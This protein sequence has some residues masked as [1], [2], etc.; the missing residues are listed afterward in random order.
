MKKLFSVL[1][2]LMFALSFNFN[3]YANFEISTSPMSQ[4]FIDYLNTPSLYSNDSSSG[5]IP[6]P[7]EL[8]YVE[9]NQTYDL[10]S[11]YNISS[12]YNIQNPKNFISPIK[13]QGQDGVC[14]A[15]STIGV[16]ESSLLKQENLTQLDTYDFSENHMRHALSK[17][18]NNLLGFER[19]H[20]G[21]GNFKMG[22]AYLTRGEI[23]GPVWEEDDIYEYEQPVRDVADTIAIGAED[24]YV[25]KSITL[26][27][28]PKKPTQAQ[29][30][31]RINEIKQLVMDYGSVTLSYY[32]DN[33][34]YDNPSEPTNYYYN[35]D[36]E[37][38]NSNHAVAIVGWDDTYSKNNF[39]YKPEND[40]AFLIKNSWGERGKL[41]G[42][43]YMSYDDKLAFSDINTIASVESR[44]FY[45]NLYEYDPFGNSGGSVGFPYDTNAYANVFELISENEILTSI[46]TNT[47]VP[48]SY[49]KFFVSTDGNFQNLEEVSIQD[50]GD[51]TD[52]GYQ[53]PDTGYT[54]FKLESPI[55]L[56][57]NKFAIAI[58]VYNP[59]YNNNGEAHTIPM[60]R[61]TS[62]Y[63][64]N[65]IQHAGESFIAQ[66]ISYLMFNQNIYDLAS[67]YQA[68]ACI[69]A[70]TK[71][72]EFEQ[73]Y[74]I[75]IAS[76]IEGGVVEAN[77][78]EAAEGTDIKLDV[79]PDDGMRLK[80]N[81]L[82]Y[83]DGNDEYI[84]R[85]N[86]FKM[87]ASDVIVY[88]E[89]EKIPYN[90]FI[91]HN[92]DGGTVKSSHLT[93]AEGTDIIVIVTPDKGMQ[94]V[95]DSLKYDDGI[96]E[97]IINNNTF[98]MP[99]SDVT[100][101]AEFE[102]A[103]YNITIDNN[104]KGGTIKSDISNAKAGTDVHL[105]ILPDE[106]MRLKENSLKYNDGTKDYIISNNTFK[107]PASSVTVYAEFEK[108]PYN[109]NIDESIAGGSVEVNY[110]TVTEG[111][112]IVVIVKAD[113]GMQ[114]KENSL[115][116][117]DGTDE[118]IIYGNTFKMPASDI[119]I[120]AEFEK[121]P[122]K[123]III[124]ITTATKDAQIYYTLDGTTPT[125]QSTK[126]TDTIKKSLDDFSQSTLTIKAIAFKEGFN[127]SDIAVKT[128]P[129]ISKSL[130]TVDKSEEL[131]ILKQAIQDANTVLKNYNDGNV[132]LNEIINALNSVSS[133]IVNYSKV[134]KV[135]TPVIKIEF[136]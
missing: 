104:I 110:L 126:Y 26:A 128:V 55:E 19:K 133:A 8:P 23:N 119:T 7:Y 16:M 89:F 37:A 76:D 96:H 78:S 44:E 36:D 114:L 121:I 99:A 87:P 38:P 123:N 80:E 107:M 77:L 11:T 45:D 125:K 84:I 5:Y 122:S 135:S 64:S 41:A 27:D 127:D 39:K 60:E 6:E 106:G 62:G 81:S 46:S 33:N 2:S 47:I 112:D 79:I 130:Y 24:F 65:A 4:K 111:T 49:L 63:L 58:E 108:I 57:S 40:G 12:K 22:L 124:E 118:H 20:D 113:E 14:W 93:A 72:V 117:R 70:F 30:N 52:R 88:A 71:S 34:Y 82:V 42:Y 15:F 17:D 9:K 3:I 51:K 56:K 95:Q 35:Y 136:K 120:Y 1:L 101:Y 97:Y 75:N 94:L 91:S 131:E 61:N 102:E 73:T 50:Y 105:T 43:F 53:I 92:I 98:K 18:G 29:K 66:N 10:P 54:T 74:T 31:A 134:S 68:N 100:I 132:D 85:N 109:I 32:S 59:D 67:R 115:V 103:P 48:N 21:G 69:K 25:T 90:I 116:Y 13:D 28:L 86:T 129:I 83:N